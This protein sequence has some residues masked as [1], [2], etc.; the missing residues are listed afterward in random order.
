MEIEDALCFNLY[1]ASRLMTQAYAKQLDKLNLTY[2]QFLVMNLLWSKDKV[3]LKT[4]GER[5]YLDSGTLT[6]LINRMVTAGYLKKVRS[7]H[8]EREILISLT[9]K[10]KVLQKKSSDVP[11]AMFCKLDVSMERFIEIRNGVHEILNN[12]NA[13]LKKQNSPKKILI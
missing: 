3:T 6:P 9:A 12:L 1:T 2:L 8:D 13:E 4:L 10:G 5:L 11:M 7:A